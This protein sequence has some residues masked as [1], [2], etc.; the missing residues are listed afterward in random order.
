M[1]S[2]SVC[3]Y[4]LFI[5]ASAC[6]LSQSSVGVPMHSIVVLLTYVVGGSSVEYA[7]AS[8]FSPKRRRGVISFL[9]RCQSRLLSFGPECP[10][11][12]LV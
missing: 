9:V 12:V 1:F 10:F 3:G 2:C 7:L 8:T 6:R 4:G 5:E 11:F